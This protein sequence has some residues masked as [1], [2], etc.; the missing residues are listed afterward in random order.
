MT[1]ELTW[2]GHGSWSLQ[3]AD[4]TVILDPFLNE[5]PTAPVKA[6]DVSADYI[7][8][9]HG[10]FDHVADVA[11]IAKRTGATV[12]TNFEISQW[13]T[14][15]QQVENVVGMNLGGQLQL[16][17]GT[18]KMTVAWHSSQ[19]PDGSDGGNPGGF[20]LTLPDGKIY[21]ACDT[22]IFSDMS[23]ITRGGVDLAVL[24]I[25]DLFTMGPDDALE[26]VKLIQPKAVIPNHYN[27]WPPIEQD[28]KAWATR[29]E[30]ET[31]T[32]A[33][34]LEPGGTYRLNG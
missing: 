13:L 10:H 24:P 5:S 21:F 6:E 27:T 14:N 15:S 3:V 32:R 12:V 1:T 8:V 33:V 9:S 31:E 23:L 17:F 22:A 16:P 30:Q 29:V 4:K 34:V 18:V 7:L 26:A 19:L 28:A 11:A 20:L 2:L 25:G